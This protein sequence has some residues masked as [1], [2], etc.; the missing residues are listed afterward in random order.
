MRNSGVHRY[1]SRFVALIHSG[2]ISLVL[3]VGESEQ[4]AAEAFISYIHL[5]TIG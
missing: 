1:K 4:L 3:Y 5:S 2:N